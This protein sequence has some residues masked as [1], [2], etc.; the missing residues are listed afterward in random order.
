M[1]SS[2]DACDIIIGA[3]GAGGTGSFVNCGRDNGEDGGDTR[4]DGV[5]A[6]GGG[7]AGLATINKGGVGG[8]STGYPSQDGGAG[9][10]G[11]YNARPMNGGNCDRYNLLCGGRGRRGGTSLCSNTQNQCGSIGGNGWNGF[12]GGGGGGFK[13][14]PGVGGGTYDLTGSNA[15]TCGSGGG[16]SCN[17]YEGQTCNWGGGNGANGLIILKWA[18]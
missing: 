10:G 16:G 6:V 14:A 1:T 3:G 12:A 11:I 15:C 18:E 7:G 2:N 17:D 9:G 8:S 13:S 5:L 4:F